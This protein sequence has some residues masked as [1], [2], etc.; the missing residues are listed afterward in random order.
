M[1]SPT[2]DLELE[3]QADYRVYTLAGDHYEMG[4]QWGMAGIGEE[5][6][7]PTPEEA[8]K[9]AQLLGLNLDQF[10]ALDA[11]VG[12][13]GVEEEA[14]SP[15]QLS[16]AEECLQVVCNFHPPLLDEFEGWA[17]SLGLGTDSILGMLSFG[18]EQIPRHCSAFAWR[19]KDGLIVGRNYDFFYW[20]KTRH[21]IHAKPDIYYATVGMN[22]GLLGGRQEGVN[23]HGLF[24]S[25]HG[26]VAKPGATRRPGVAFHLVPRILL[27]TCATAGEAVM[28]A[29]EMPH[30]M[31]YSY[32]IADSQKMFVVEAHPE[33]V[34]IRESDDH[35]IATTN[36]FLHPELKGL[37]Q[38]PVQKNSDHRLSRIAAAL[39]EA[40]KE[41]EPWPT[42]RSIL[43]DHEAPICGHTDGLATLWSMIA[44][45]T[46][47]RLAYSLGA[48]CRNDYQ[49]IPWPGTSQPTAPTHKSQ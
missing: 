9:A 39:A 25:V 16:F 35:Y 40:E 11:A 1:V 8:A 7:P 41:N 10:A 43:T 33:A 18:M 32:L 21:L 48:P 46:N 34:C 42:A 37:M 44:D 3:K 30:L 23:E 31:S 15:S 17:E 5:T 38:S 47:Q 19:T 13:E 22:D 12:A 49:E 45:L 6:D 29:R 36:H 2:D 26:V 24:V 4:R 14:L 28:L 20:A 27:E